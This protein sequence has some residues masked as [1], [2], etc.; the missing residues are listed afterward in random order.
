MRPASVS[1]HTPTMLPEY[2]GLQQNFTEHKASILF[3]NTGT[4]P[5]MQTL[6]HH[7]AQQVAYTDGIVSELPISKL[8]ASTP[9]S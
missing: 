6:V 9:N 5:N 8:Q 4:Q 1:F 3:Y 2:F 7:Y